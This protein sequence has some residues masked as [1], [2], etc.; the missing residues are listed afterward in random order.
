MATLPS[1]R[2]GKWGSSHRIGSDADMGS[3]DQL[4]ESLKKE[5]ISR[6]YSAF[7]FS[8]TATVFRASWLLISVFLL[9]IAGVSLF[10]TLQPKG[11][12]VWHL[13]IKSPS[14]SEGRVLR[15]HVSSSGGDRFEL[16]E[17]TPEMKSGPLDSPRNPKRRVDL[18]QAADSTKEGRSGKVDRSDSSERRVEDETNVIQTVVESREGLGRRGGHEVRMTASDVSADVEAATPNELVTSSSQVASTG[19]HRSEN[20]SKDSTS[21][22]SDDSGKIGRGEATSIISSDSSPTSGGGGDTSAGVETGTLDAEREIS[23]VTA[24]VAGKAASVD[25][26]PAGDGVK[27]VRGGEETASGAEA[28]SGAATNED[29]GIHVFVSTDETDL[30]PIAVV[31]NST[32]VNAREPWRVDFH[33]VVPEKNVA[34]MKKKLLPLFPSTPI[35][36]VS[37]SPSLASG[38]SAAAAAAPPAAAANGGTAAGAAGASGMEMGWGERLGALITYKEGSGARKELVSVFNFLPFYLPQ[39][40]PQFGRIVYLDADIVVVGDIGELADVDMEGR[41]VAAVEDCM[42]TFKT[43]FD[44]DQLAEIQARNDPSKPWMPSEP[45]DK[46]TCV[47]NR[48][49]LLMDV[50]RWLQSNISGAIEWWMGEFSRAPNPLYKFGMSQPPFLLTIY[51]RY[52]KLDRIW[53]TR[54]LGRDRFG[55]KERDYLAT[56]GLGRPPKRPFVSFWADA[57]K[58]LHFNGKFKPWRGK[59]ERREGEEVKSVCGERRTDC[60]KLWWK[61]LSLGGEAELRRKGKGKKPSV[62]SS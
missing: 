37:I 60:A 50:Q 15:I 52:K 4:L 8:T 55:E 12:T 2:G 26:A 35:H 42:Q 29:K 48:G 58:I 23:A 54:G 7:G 5:P 24:T 45:F 43:Y 51:D 6:R 28:A 39:M 10:I 62:A 1:Q 36:I 20:D 44:F 33:L 19:S 32:L 14:S 22:T 41:P 25:V 16:E 53:N 46:T 11:F 56:I 31:I 34:A 59:R 30:R 9:A 21:A 49:V 13:T 38:A 18:D 3:L 27:D 47:F 61:Y 57:A 40:A 17:S